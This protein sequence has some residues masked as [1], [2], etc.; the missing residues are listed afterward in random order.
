[1]YAP[2]SEPAVPAAI[3]SQSASAGAPPVNSPRAARNPAGIITTSL[4]KGMKLDSTVMNTKT[5]ASPHT[6]AYA[7]IVPR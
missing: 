6:G 7:A 2:A 1:M 4:G 5:N 3:A